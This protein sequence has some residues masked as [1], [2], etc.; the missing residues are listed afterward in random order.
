M[1]FRWPW[2]RR[3]P[4]NGEAAEAVKAREEAAATLRETQL[5][6]PEVRRAGDV[7]AIQVEQALRRTR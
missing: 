2:R 7:L 3:D 5:R 6:W 4:G 1:R